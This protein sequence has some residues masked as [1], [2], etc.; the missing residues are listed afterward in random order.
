MSVLLPDVGAC[1]SFCFL[2]STKEMQIFRV[3]S[4]DDNP[5]HFDSEFATSSGLLGPIVFGGLLIAKISRLLGSV[6]PGHGCIWAGTNVSFVSP[7]YIG[8][9]AVL[10]AEVIQVSSAVNFVKIGH[11]IHCGK[12]LILRG[13]SE[14][15][16][17]G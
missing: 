13:C 14:V 11:R 9:E 5:I 17:R 8:E 3:L 15:I 1:V 10:D 16:I 4:G 12:R 6:L 7:L 2:I